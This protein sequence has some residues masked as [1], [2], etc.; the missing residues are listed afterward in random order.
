MKYAIV[1]F[2]LLFIYIKPVF[3][4]K[5]FEYKKYIAFDGK[6]F[7][8]KEEAIYYEK[9]MSKVEILMKAFQ[10]EIGNLKRKKIKDQ[11]E[12]IYLYGYDPYKIE[13]Y[14]NYRDLLFECF[15]R[16]D[17]QGYEIEVKVN[18]KGE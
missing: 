12:N 6:V 8:N 16:F 14:D 13:R 3:A 10:E 18:K 15:K 2:L 17:E 4:L 11:M 1:V 9:I 7:D 5:E